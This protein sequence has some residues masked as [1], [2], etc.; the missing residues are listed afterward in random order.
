MATLGQGLTISSGTLNVSGGAPTTVEA[1]TLTGGNL[2]GSDTLTVTGATTWSN[3]TMSGSGVT[4]AEGG[5]AMGGTYAG[6]AGN[7]HYT[8]YLSARTLENLGTATLDSPYSYPIYDGLWL[9]SGSTLINEPGASFDLTSNAQIVA[10]G[11]S[12]GGGTVLNEGTFAKTG[13][14]G[15]SVVGV[16]YTGG[17]VAFDNQGNG[18]VSA[19]SGT[20]NLENALVVDGLGYVNIAPAAA[21]SLSGGLTGTTTDTDLFTPTHRSGFT[22]NGPGS[23]NPPELFEVM[24]QDMGD[25][26]AGFIDNGAYGSI[27]LANGAYVRLVDNVQ[28]SQ[29]TGP[30]ALYVNSLSVPAGTTLDLN[31]LNVYTRESLVNGTVLNGTIQVLPPGGSLGLGVPLPG[32]I[33]APGQVNTWTF[34][35]WAGRGVTILANP[36]GSAAPAAL[37]PYLNNVTVSLVDPND[38]VLAS[39]TSASSG[40]VVTLAGVALPSDGTYTVTVKAS[41]SQPS[42]TG[43][44]L[45]GVYDATVNTYAASFGQPYTGT[46]ATAYDVDHWTFSANAN[47]QIQFKLVAASN[48]TLEFTLSGPNGYVGFQDIKASAGLL[49][50]PA[51]GGYTL[52]ADAIG[53]QAGSYSFQIN[54]T[55]I[56]S[57]TPRTTYQGALAGSGQPQLFQIS[58]AQ[59]QSLLVILDDTTSTD[60]DELYLKYGSPP[61]RS[62]YQYRCANL[63]SASEQILVSGA[64]GGTWY[65]LVYTD[66]VPSPSTYTIVATSGNIFLTGST[67]SRSGTSAD[68]VLTLTGA[69]FDQTTSVELVGASDIAFAPTS[70]SIDLPTQITA[71]FAAGSI[72]AGTYNVEVSKP[73]LQPAILPNALTVAQG[74]QAMFEANL[75]VPNPMTRHIA[76]TLYIDYSN[77]GK[78]TI[79]APMLILS[80]TNPDGQQGALLTLDPALQG[81]GLWTNTTPVGYSQ[82]IE[83]LASGATPGILAPGES[84]S[85]PVYY[86]GW[87]TSQWDFSQ[88]TLNFSL[89]TIQT[90]NT[91]AMNW[92]GATYVSGVASG[93]VNILPFAA[94]APWINGVPQTESQIEQELDAGQLTAEF[95][96]FYATFGLD[97]FGIASSVNVPGIIQSPPPSMPAA[98]WNEIASN[99]EASIGGTMGDYVQA[100][101]TEAAYLGRL[102]EDV[103]DISSLW[104]IEV[105]QADAELNPLDP[106]LASAT[107][108]SVSTPGDL[109]L[110]R[111]LARGFGVN[112]RA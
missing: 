74:G 53:G 77:T 66:S 30:E 15:L 52:S 6:P 93:D 39:G 49:T 9:D 16:N 28:N 108:D 98:A 2:T 54:L 95:P 103:N 7:I 110:S 63:P 106:Y 89:E 29:G 32:D 36:G 18:S 62:D 5:M 40:S 34:Y 67:P 14:S 22:I 71:T 51:S 25:T 8:E 69:G 79:P 94:V 90:T 112:L 107:D 92:N 12:P 99:L 100:L 24:S 75:V 26:P 87:I 37:A 43:H 85:I 44:Y 97:N 38:N 11:G 81:E 68:T 78:V 13:G 60:Q 109:Y 50:L 23:S 104:G 35:G 10:N 31:G 55:S 111:S 27:S 88:S 64:D 4:I 21:L 33:T 102:G 82:T 46:L 1:L 47:Q 80:A 65:A 101:D 20:L 84:E 3:G 58:L 61:T 72:P 105:Q 19:L 57:L 42:S 17:T 56:V 59:A 76:E 70:T 73:G 86:G 45:V 83:V 48:P 96:P 91:E 41:S